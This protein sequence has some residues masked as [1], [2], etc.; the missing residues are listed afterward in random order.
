MKKLL[1]IL[2]VVVLLVGSL[3]VLTACDNDKKEEKKSSDI[4]VSK[5]SDEEKIEHCLYARLKEI[6]GKDLESAKIYVDKMYKK[7]DVENN[8][9]LKTLDLG[10]KDIAFEVTIHI[11]PA[12]GTD[13]NTLALPDGEINGESGWVVFNRLGVLKY[14]NGTYTIENYGTGW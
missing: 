13:V 9:I 3:C 5:L 12:E 6:Y 7:A 2:L 14:N 10:E 4:D 11:E 1:T 8:E